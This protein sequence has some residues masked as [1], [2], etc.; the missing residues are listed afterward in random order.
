MQKVSSHNPPGS[1]IQPGG[2]SKTLGR[3]IRAAVNTSEVAHTCEWLVDQGYASDL[4]HAREL[5]DSAFY[6]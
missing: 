5:V 6:R 1:I 3:T 2:L 4:V